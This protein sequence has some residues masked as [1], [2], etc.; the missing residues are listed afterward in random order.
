MSSRNFVTGTAVALLMC[1]V[2]TA[3]LAQQAGQIQRWVQNQTATPPSSETPT[4]AVRVENEPASEVTEAVGEATD[5]TEALFTTVSSP[6]DRP[7]VQRIV[8][9]ARKREE[10]AQ[11]VPISIDVTQGAEIQRQAYR[12]LQE[13]AATLPA[14]NISR[15]GTTDFINIRGVGSGLSTTFE[16]SVGTIID[17][18]AVGRSR[19]TRAGLLDLE[20]V[21]VLKGPQTTFFGANTIAGALNIVSR[22]ASLDAGFTGY[23]LSSYEFE[24]E[25]IIVEAAANVPVSETFAF[26]LAAKW[27]DSEGFIENTGRGEEQPA[28]EDLVFRGSA[29]WAPTSDLTAEAVFTY[30]ELDANSFLDLELENCV[31]GPV[32]STCTNANGQPVNDRL[33]YVTSTDIDEFRSLDFYIGALNVAYEFNG[34]TLT[35]VTGYYDFETDG[36]AD[37]DGTSVPSTSA[38]SRLATAQFDDAKQISQELRIESPRGGTFEWLA[39]IYLSDEDTDFASIS[40][41]AFSPPAPGAQNIG[42]LR[43]QEAKTYSA[44]GSVTYN[45]ATDLRAILGL[46]Y[47]R[48]TKDIAVSSNTLGVVPANGIPDAR[49][50]RPAGGITFADLETTDDAVTPALTVQYDVDTN[51]QVYGSFRRGFKAGGADLQSSQVGATSGFASTYEP[52]T[53]NAIEFGAKGEYLDGRLRANVAAFLALYQDRQVASLA[54]IPPGGG[55]LTQPVDNA[56]RSRAYGIEFDASM[57]VTDK[58]TILGDVTLLNSKFTEYEDAPCF[59]GQISGCNGGT[60]DLSGEETTFAPKYSGNFAAIYEQPFGGY[61]VTV[62]P[63]VFFSDSYFFLDTFNPAIEQESFVK[64]NLRLGVSPESGQWELAVIG[65]NLND[66]VTANFCQ[67]AAVAAGGS[68]GCALDTP[69]T[70]TIQGRINF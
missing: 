39:G 13:L 68:F 53:V 63:S 36:L 22:K 8:V 38:Q 16:Q 30:G 6:Q 18:V 31:G 19:I 21:E 9:T 28:N 52:E 2:S 5:D 34:Y 45:F 24:Q 41:Q 61:V 65:R 7:W 43:E 64:A 49:G 14:V 69:R 42:V 50:F 17:G 27:T 26:R 25:E 20:R 40:L 51:T 32:Q 37:L 35:S 33:D 56:A 57:E 60:Q 4:N 3:A 70:V 58:L 46:R 11:D 54:N 59:T 48:V 55:G 62:Q 47:I 10:L 12:D 1:S 29:I 67:E 66:E 15:A 23:L 44:F